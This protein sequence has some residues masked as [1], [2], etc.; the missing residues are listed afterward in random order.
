[1]KRASFWTAAAFVALVSSP[2]L[3][4]HKGKVPWVE[5][6]AEGFALAKRTGKPAMLFFSAEW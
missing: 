6:P 4:D 1:M 2:A 3:A 5:P